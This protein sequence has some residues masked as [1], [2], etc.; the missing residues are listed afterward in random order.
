[1]FP[2]NFQI[3]EQGDWLPSNSSSRTDRRPIP[4]QFIDDDL[5]DLHNA[6]NQP[7]STYDYHSRR[8]VAMSSTSGLA[9]RGTGSSRATDTVMEDDDDL[10]QTQALVPAATPMTFWDS[11]FQI[12]LERFKTLWPDEPQGRAKSGCNYSIRTKSTWEDIYDQ[13]QKAREFYDGDTKGLWGRHAK[14]Y[15]KKKRSFIDHT[16]PIARQAVRFVPQMEY[17]T[18][19]VAAV[20][21][22]VDVSRLKPDVDL[23][24]SFKGS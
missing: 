16:V 8:Y 15:T 22:L 1:M 6:L 21:V 18:P 9:R 19:V 13:L 7:L 12:S 20:Q 24:V 5:K 17:T 4:V 14:S 2:V 3:S 10:T 11:V 23:A